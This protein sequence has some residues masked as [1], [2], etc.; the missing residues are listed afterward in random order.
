MYLKAGKNNKN[1]DNDDAGE[2]EVRDDKDN[3]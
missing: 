3:S 1:D 2:G